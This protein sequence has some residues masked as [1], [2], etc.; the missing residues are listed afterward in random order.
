VASPEIAPG[1][2]AFCAA[3]IQISVVAK[4]QPQKQAVVA[5]C[6]ELGDPLAEKR[7][8]LVKSDNWLALT[9]GPVS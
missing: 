3:Q 5:S 2:L 7:P 9:V 8:F 1:E 6:E 4:Q